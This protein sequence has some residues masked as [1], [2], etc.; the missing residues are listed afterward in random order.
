MAS[1]IHSRLRADD[2]STV[3]VKITKKTSKLTSV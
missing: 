1:Y 3:H 2:W